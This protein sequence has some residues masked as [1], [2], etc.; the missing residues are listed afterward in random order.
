MKSM[1]KVVLRESLRKRLA[2]LR[3]AESSRILA[4][5]AD[6]PDRVPARAF[7]DVDLV[8]VDECIRQM[9]WVAHTCYLE[10]GESAGIGINAVVTP[11]PD[12]WKP[13]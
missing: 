11:A 10:A 13:E 5:W 3:N 8:V 4:L 2:E 1:G 7:I 6:S 12:D 9:E